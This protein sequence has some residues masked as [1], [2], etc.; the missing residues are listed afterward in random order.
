MQR[1]CVL[2]LPG[3][4]TTDERHQLALRA[5]TAVSTAH[6]DV[7]ALE[8]GPVELGE[9]GDDDQAAGVTQGKGKLRQFIENHVKPLLAKVASRLWAIISHL[10]TPKEWQITGDVS[11]GIPALGMA[12]VELA[13]TFGA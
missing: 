9:P 6:A 7:A 4:E 11:G 10:L 2:S 1:V 13:I 12:K 5:T 8:A 3:V